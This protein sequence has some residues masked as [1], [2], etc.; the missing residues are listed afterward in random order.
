MNT[1][2]VFFMQ[3]FFFKDFKN[4]FIPHILKEIYIDKV[5]ES[6]L[7]ARKDLIT[8]DIGA[9]IGLFSYYASTFSKRVYSVEPSAQHIE[10]MT[11]MMTFNGIKNMTVIQ[12]AV[13]HQNGFADFFHNDNTTM[14]SLKQ[15]VKG[16]EDTEKVETTTL[17]KLFD[18]FDIKHVDL[19]KIDIEGS[20]AEVFGSESFDQV[21]EKIDLIVGEFHTWSGVNPQLFET[22]FLDRNFSFDWLN[23]TEATVFVA[24]RNR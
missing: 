24:K 1:E 13:S 20:E 9:N 2:G 4:A 18:D 23:K 8:L 14:F 12:K 6:L 3:G 21:K 17:K 11:Q 7:P 10:E 16:N 15:E 22:Y 19:M 5:Y